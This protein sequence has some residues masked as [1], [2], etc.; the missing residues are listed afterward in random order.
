MLLELGLIDEGAEILR[1]LTH[2]V[3]LP[4]WINSQ[5]REIALKYGIQ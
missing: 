2:K 4:L 3:T 5:A 1:S